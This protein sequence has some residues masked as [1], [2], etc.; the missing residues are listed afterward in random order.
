MKPAAEPRF[1]LGV[2]PMGPFREQNWTRERET[3]FLDR[4]LELPNLRGL[5]IPF[6]SNSQI[7]QFDPQLFLQYLAR[8]AKLGMQHVLTCIVGTSQQLTTNPHFG[9]ASANKVGR[10]QA[11]EFIRTAHQ[12]VK[13]L[14]KTLG[15]S[16]I[17]ALELH[18]APSRTKP[19]VASTSADLRDSLQSIAEWDWGNV[20]LSVEH[21]D[22]VDS[23]FPPVKGFLSL[24]D[25][26]T[27]VRAV[28]SAL[29][30][31]KPIG[32]TINWGRSAIEQRD[33][34]TP[35]QQIVTCGKAGLLAGVMFSGVTDSQ[36][37]SGKEGAWLDSHAPHARAAGLD[38][39]YEDSLMTEE[40]MHDC[41]KAAAP[42]HPDYLG[43]KIMRRPETADYDETPLEERIG[44]LHSMLLLLKRSYTE[45]AK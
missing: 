19:G 35:H 26:L 2:Y 17:L 7:H 37:R 10:E 22:S 29:A 21:C 39:F 25:E 9:L 16:S 5:E 3:N 14:Q 23:P 28:N 8:G 31:P 20:R 42:F 45:T 32:L 36:K 43:A 6:P 18:S 41:L 12:Q 38:Y 24:D 34:E 40:R 30:L 27:A 1:I 44:L 13:Q 33:P 15:E 11:V 4:V